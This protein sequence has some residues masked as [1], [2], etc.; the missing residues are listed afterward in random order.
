MF[1]KQNR[2]ANAWNR[3]YLHL[4]CLWNDTSKKITWKNMAQHNKQHQYGYVGMADNLISK[5]YKII[6]FYESLDK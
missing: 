2:K 4:S 5:V 1:L 3:N 6:K